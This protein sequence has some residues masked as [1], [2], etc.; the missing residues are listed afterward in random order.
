[1][2]TLRIENRIHDYDSW[3]A[4]FDKF[5]VLRREKGVRAYRI[6][7]EADEPLH[8]FIDLDFDSATRAEDFRET[9]AKI[10]RTPQSREQ[11]TD[12]AEP[13]VLD[14]LT[15]TRYPNAIHPLTVPAP[16]KR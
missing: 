9:L 7:R 3:K 14:V 6:S 8:V 4:A 11:L 2:N 15:E 10:W 1:M 13:V 12:H 16:M 5:D